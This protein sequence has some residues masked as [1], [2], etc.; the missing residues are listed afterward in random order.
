MFKKNYPYFL[1][2]ILLVLSF[3]PFNLFFLAFFALVP[4]LIKLEEEKNFFK[5]LFSG[6]IFNLF[7]L[8]WLYPV[9]TGY[10]GM[11]WYFALLSLF[12]LYSYLALYFAIPL[13]FFKRKFVWI[14]PFFYIAFE[15]ILEHFLTGFPWGILAN[16]QSSNTGINYIF[17]FT[18]I[19]GVSFLILLSNIAL[20]LS[21]KKKNFFKAFSL[22]VIIFIINIAGYFIKDKGDEILKIAVVQGNESMN[23][24]WTGKRVVNEFKKYMYYTEKSVKEG[25]N[26]I[27]WPEFCYPYYPR[28]N[29]EITKILKNYTEKNN[30]MLILGA[31]DLK[32]GDYFNT[33]F[34]FYRGKYDFYHK[35]HLTPFGEYIPYKKLFFFANKIANVEG[36]FTK[37]QNIRVFDYNGIKVGIP[38]CYEMIFP[39]LIKRFY[40]R[41]INLLITITNDSWFGKTSGPFEHFYI[42][43]VRAMETSLPVARAATS[44]ISGIF[45]SK[46]KIL[47]RLSYGK[48]GYL[49]SSVKINKPSFSPFYEFYYFIKYTI[50]FLFFIY[51]FLLV[52]DKTRI[53][54]GK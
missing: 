2:P 32:D 1:T 19:R 18:G 21:F 5:L 43:K 50:F 12:L 23:T 31:N 49:I 36:E 3:P 39:S 6:F 53:K 29:I 30:V 10:G 33:A 51:I 45:N 15:V 8:Y 35:V 40:D 20:Y 11:P 47:K 17:Y 14:F 13:Y 37:G 25:A 34:V 38:I 42:S 24:V 26:I 22:I 16:S 54:E 28:F 48:E 7:L 52:K 27:V 4:I 41:G 9:L 46:G 44:G